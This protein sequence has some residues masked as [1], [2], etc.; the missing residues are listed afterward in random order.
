MKAQAC[1]SEALQFKPEHAELYNDLGVVLHYQGKLDEAV[2]CYDEALRL[3]PD[4]PGAR[5]NRG[6]ALAQ[7]R[8]RS[9]GGQ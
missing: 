4:Y 6:K 5:N 1:Y 2:A 8:V 3:K 7:L 9:A